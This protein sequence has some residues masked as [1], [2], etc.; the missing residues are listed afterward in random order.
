MPEDGHNCGPIACTKI[1]EIYGWIVLGSRLPQIGESLGGFSSVVMEFF[2][3]F[4]TTYDDDLQVELRSSDGN[5][6]PAL[7][8]NG[9]SIPALGTNDKSNI[10]SISASSVAAQNEYIANATAEKCN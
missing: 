1:M 2:S 3:A 6:L 4:L 5:R 7:G 10:I 9:E 8:T